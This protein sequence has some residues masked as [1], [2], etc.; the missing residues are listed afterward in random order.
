MADDEE[1]VASEMKPEPLGC[2]H[3][4]EATGEKSEP[5]GL[6]VS[7]VE[8]L[9]QGI[10]T[11]LLTNKSVLSSEIIAWEGMAL[12]SHTAN[13][14]FVPEHEHPTHFLQLQTRGPVRYEVSTGGKTISET[15]GPGTI[16]V[17]PRGTQDHVLW[18]GP[19][20]RIA[21]VLHPRLLARTLEETAHC[22]DLELM[23]HW[24]LRDRRI[25]SLMLALYTDIEDGS[26]AGRLYGESIGTALSV[27]L[28]QKFAV[29]RPKIASYRGGIPSAR[30]KR[31]TD[32][33]EAHLDEDI[34]LSALAEVAGMGTHYFCELFKQSMPLSPYQYVLQKR[35]ERAKGYLREPHLKMIDVGVAVGFKNQSHFARVFKRIVGATPTQ[36]RAG[37]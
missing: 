15:A 19:T 21:V 6:T 11:P 35:I 33:I 12:E 29:F 17:C 26:S 30:L 32:Y 5:W 13:S 8:V 36:F 28:T 24:N 34:S 10:L 1:S 16:F 27:Y 3:A 37:K 31:V 22:A 25:E 23:E 4:K 7:G 18:K 14:C 20:N 2:A 9:R